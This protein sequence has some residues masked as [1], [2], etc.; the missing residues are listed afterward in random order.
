M[1]MGVFLIKPDVKH[2]AFKLESFTVIKNAKVMIAC[3]RVKFFIVYPVTLG[4]YLKLLYKSK[5]NL[6][7]SQEKVLI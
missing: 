3:K 2:N 7:K 5:W 6:V 1:P 4:K